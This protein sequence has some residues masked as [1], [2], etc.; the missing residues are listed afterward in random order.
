MKK[1][2]FLLLGSTAV[3][4]V[5]VPA[6]AQLQ[7]IS[8]AVEKA[9]AQ[10]VVGASVGTAGVQQAVAAQQ[11]LAT[12]VTQIHDAVWSYGFYRSSFAFSI[13]Q[14]QKTRTATLPATFHPKLHTTLAQSRAVLQGTEVLKS[15]QEKADFYLYDLPYLIVEDKDPSYAKVFPEAADFYRQV[16]SAPAEENAR[17]KFEVWGR[18]M[19]AITGL[20]MTGTEADI[21][22][23]LNAAKNLPGTSENLEWTT[24]IAAG[25]LVSFGEPGYKAVE[26]LFQLRLAEGGDLSWGWYAV[27]ARMGKRLNIPRERM[28]YMI[29]PLEVRRSLIHFNAVNYALAC[30]MTQDNLLEAY[31]DLLQASRQFRSLGGNGESLASIS[32]TLKQGAQRPKFP[33]QLPSMKPVTAG[34]GYPVTIPGTGQVITARGAQTVEE[35][36][37]MGAMLQ[38]IQKKIQINQQFLKS[39]ETELATLQRRQ[40]WLLLNHGRRG[41]QISIEEDQVNFLNELIK[42]GRES[43]T[44]ATAAIQEGKTLAQM[45]DIMYGVE[46]ATPYHV[47]LSEDHYI[48]APGA[49]TPWEAWKMQEY[50]VIARSD[51]FRSAI[52]NYGEIKQ[53]IEEGKSVQEIGLMVDPRRVREFGVGT[54]TEGTFMVVDPATVTFNDEA[55]KIWDER[56]GELWYVQDRLTRNEYYAVESIPASGAKTVAEAEQMQALLMRAYKGKNVWNGDTVEGYNAMR[57]AIREGEPLSVVREIYEKYF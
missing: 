26:D 54:P 11:M 19:S 55:R 20:S 51:R 42:E 34:G 37:E 53:A 50:L 22:L 9:V 25:H 27:N 56:T 7:G 8:P 35:A 44:R 23:I 52:G 40:K 10:Q 47:M 36:K 57:N 45:R 48:G 4:A 17:S 18:K 12:A 14:E 46:T 39:N 5:A 31:S 28:G 32:A 43:L 49:K 1:L 6:R 21:P 2:L 15:L 24:L 29:P 3:C 16:L 13:I 33:M 38:D 41:V 30:D